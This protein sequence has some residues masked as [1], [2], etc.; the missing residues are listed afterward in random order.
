[1][2]RTVRILVANQPRLMRE[3]MLET[4]AELPGIEIVGEVSNEADIPVRVMQTSPDLLVIA[5]EDPNRR[6]NICDAVLH[7][8][9][10]LHIL[11]VAFQ[12]NRTVCY[13]ASLDIH[14][15]EI[16]TSEQGILNAVRSISEGVGR[17]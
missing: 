6:P 8:H 2:D 10:D 7:D 16:E 5:L 15:N 4:L 3:L 14:A 17:S 11:A 12:E 9:P 1:M 13:W